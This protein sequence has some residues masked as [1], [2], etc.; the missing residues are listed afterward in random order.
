MLLR[1]YSGRWATG[2]VT[3]E[4]LA[5]GKAQ[6][7]YGSCHFSSLPLHSTF[8][9]NSSLP[10][11]LAVVCIMD[12]TPNTCADA[13]RQERLQRRRERERQQRA[14]E[15]SED[16]EQRLVVCADVLSCSHLLVIVAIGIGHGMLAHTSLSQTM[17]CIRLVSMKTFFEQEWMA[18]T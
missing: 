5:I 13:V 3:I 4:M 9:A 11:T 7:P 1:G 14:E 17:L 10:S 15:T 12:S 18:L 8:F 6:S 16:R 2:F